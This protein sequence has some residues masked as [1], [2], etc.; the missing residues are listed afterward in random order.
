M[1]RMLAAC[2]AALFAL[3]S[4]L[5][6]AQ[7]GDGSLRGY[8]K[9]EQGGVLPGVTVTGTSPALQAAVVG[10]TDST[11]Y[12]RLN[13]LPPGTFTVSAEL[14]GFSTTRREGIVIRAGLTF[15]VDLEMKVGALSETVTVSGDSPM[16][17][18]SKPTST[19][20][21]DGELLRAAPV[22]SRRLF[23]D[24]LDVA[25]GVGSRNVDDGVGRRAYYFHGS[26]IYAHAF[27]LEGAP[28]SAYIDAAAHSMGMGG[29]T[30]QDVEVKLGGMD[31]SSPSSTGVVMN[32]VTPSGGNT[33]RGSA[34]YSYPTVVVEQRQHQGR[35]GARRFA[36]LPGGQPDRRDA[37][38]TADEGQAV[39]LW[40][41]PL[42]GSDQRHQ[43]ERRRPRAPARVQSRLRAVRQHVEEPSAVRQ[44]DQRRESEPADLRLVAMTAIDSPTRANVRRRRASTRA[45]PGAR[46][47]R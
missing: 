3:L 18:T 33:F 13:N 41:L 36:D 22:T 2:L 26:H 21:M 9:D 39:V 40:D 29:D 7:T 25:P 11:G 38:R 16:I 10:V 1:Q 12:Y 43:Q 6:S 20:N 14:T 24:V 17:E 5:A 34:A 15:T 4:S 37:R 46:S 44:G 23:S 19:L 30:I 32:I 42:R 27:Q 31:A 35:R 8:V 28:A 45:A 47:I